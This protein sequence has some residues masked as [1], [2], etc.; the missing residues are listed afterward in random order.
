VVTYGQVAALAGRPR[1]AREVGWIAAAGGADVPW[2]RVIN[3]A[4]GLAAGYTAG[5]AGHKRALQRDGVRVRRDFTVD[6]RRYQWWPGP[7]VMKRLGLPAE[8]IAR[9][10]RARLRP[11]QDTAN[12]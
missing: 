8:A 4:G 3:R 10:A 1:A 11:A 5:R 7:G 2:Q 6:L 9:A 12:S